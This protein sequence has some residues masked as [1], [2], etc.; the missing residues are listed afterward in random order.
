MNDAKSSSDIKANTST[1]PAKLE[2]NK[3]DILVKREQ[4]KKETAARVAAQAAAAASNTIAQ[5]PELARNPSSSTLSSLPNRPDAPIP[6]LDRHS[7]SRHEGPRDNRD[8]R[9]LGGTRDRSRDLTGDRRLDPN[10]RD[11]GRAPNR[12]NN[13]ARPEPPPR[14]SGD[15]TTRNNNDRPSLNGGR[16]SGVS[17]RFSRDGPM[18]PPKQP[19]PPERPSVTTQDKYPPVNPERQGLINPERAALIHDNKVDSRSNSPRST[20]DD[21]R[22]RTSRG[23]SPK[24]PSHEREHADMRRDERPHRN[25]PSEPLNKPTH[26]RSDDS[27]PPPMGPRNER[28]GDRPTERNPADRRVPPPFQPSQPPSRPPMDL[29]HGRLSRQPESSYG[30][31]NQV[32]DIPSGPRDRNARNNRM[33]SAPQPRLEGR[34]AEASRALT[35]EKQ[36]PTGPSSSRARRAA[37]GQVEDTTASTAPPSIASQT[38]PSPTM[39]PD[40]MKHFSSLLSP[41]PPVQP[42]QHPE[43]PV[44]SIPTGMHPDRAKAFGGE[45]ESRRNM[46]APFQSNSVRPEP[47]SHTSG[48]PPAGPRGA[49]NDPA[50]PRM[51]GIAAP[52]GPASATER[53][54][55]VRRPKMHEINSHLQE[56]NMG[57]DRGRSRRSAGQPGTPISGPSTPVLAPPPPPPPARSDHSGR[58]IINLEGADF[59]STP[60]SEDRNRGERDRN[61]R[62]E[63]GHRGSRRSSRSPDRGRE[64]KRGPGEGPDEGRNLREEYRDCRPSERE[65]TRDHKHGPRDIGGPRELIEG[66]DTG[67]DGIGRGG[68]AREPRRDHRERDAGGR[69]QQHDA[70][71]SGGGDRGGR[72]WDPRGDGNRRDMRGSRDEG[73]GGG[74]GGG[75]RKRRSEGDALDGRGHEKR[76]R[77]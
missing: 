29:E 41:P 60:S 43:P 74:G 54:V 12:S 47:P 11:F 67:F 61:S 21:P 42:I 4:V 52:T 32:P 65:I 24:P 16:D 7:G 19:A 36:P 59:T 34:V 18:P 15:S 17:G 9:T 27:Q 62:H 72:G 1:P 57:Q 56:N 63:R 8:L 13:R 69:E 71:W 23:Q 33:A 58:D 26:G 64:P 6:R 55:R 45:P 22:D 40:R 30:R 3:S 2:S 37:P 5:R 46:P 75:G 38:L 44:N 66:R 53:A 31:L 68:R 50:T 35:P 76:M 70:P 49:H 73:G 51:N 39:H 20:K 25:G 48:G 77:R 10:S 14:W 28:P